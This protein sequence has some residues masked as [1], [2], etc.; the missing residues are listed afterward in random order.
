MINRQ[1]A[2]VLLE[3]AQ[4]YP[5]VAITGPRQSGKTTLSRQL[6]PH[7]PYVNLEELDTRQFAHTDPRGFLAQF[8]EGAVLDEVQNCPELFSYLQA[9][10]DTQQ[11]MGLF[12]LTGSQQFG[13]VSKITQSLAGR[14]GILQ[15][16]PFTFTELQSASCEPKTLETLL[17][18]GLYP[19]IYDRQIPPT[20]WYNDYIM[21]YLE[22]D[23]RQLIQVQ[24][25]RT[26]HLF[27]QMCASRTGQLLNLSSLARDCGITHNTAKA[28]ISVLEASYIL[29]L[30]NPHHRNF[31]KRLTK[32]PK[33]YFY[34]TG[35]AC[36][37]LNLQNSDILRTHP[38][39][40]A[41]FET[42]VVSELTKRRFNQGLL[43]NLYFWRDQQGLEVDVLIEQND[44]LIPI[45]I[46]SGTT[47]N[48]DFFT[49][50]NSWQAL[51]NNASHGW[52]L[53]GGD[54]SQPRSTLTVLGWKEV[55]KMP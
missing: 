33:L 20:R 22:R 19:P 40:G 36:A 12:V 39:R 43:S 32:S 13:L 2:R 5:I 46:K 41:L 4:Q 54:Q 50:L 35:L 45:E 31:N 29:F 14:V 1:A 15:L 9:L 16:L 25:L 6:F 55:G 37:L 53:Y 38:M 24:D 7:K 44:E 3:K 42:W 11:N 8:K 51:S 28:W 10:V 49:G 30:L 23:V 52:L 48:A 18:Q 26:F 17:F 34:D 27:L 47:L 21:T